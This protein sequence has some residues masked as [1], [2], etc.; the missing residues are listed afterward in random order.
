MNT[1]S[2]KIKREEDDDG[3]SAITIDR[4]SQL[5][6]PVLHNILSLL[7]Q[8]DAIRTSVLSNSWRYL[9][10]GRLN[11]EFRDNWFAR[12]PEL[13]SFLDKTLQRY[14]DHNFSLQKF[15]VDIRSVV[16]YTLL[17]KWISMA[18]TNM[19][20]KSLNLIF[21][22]SS[23]D[24]RRPLIAFLSETLVELHLQNCNLN[25][26]KSTD[27]VMLNNLRTLLLHSVYITDENFDKIISGCPLIEKLYLLLMDSINPGERMKAFID[28]PNILYFAYFGHG[29]LPSIKF[30]TTSNEWASHI[31][32]WPSDNDAMSW[33][34][35][36]N[37]LLKALSQSHIT[38]NLIH[39]EYKKLNII[40]SY[41]GFD[42]PVVVKHLGL[43]GYFSSSSFR[44]ILNCYF[45]VCRP[46]YIH[47]DQ[48]ANE[49][50]DIHMDQYAN[51][52]AEFICNLIPN[53]IGWCYSWLQ[54]LE[55][56]RIEVLDYK[57]K[58]WNCF[59]GTTLPS[60]Q[61]FRFRLTWREQLSKLT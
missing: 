61:R 7:S 42:K 5:P 13:W 21:S 48:Y 41:G 23:I 26:L 34:L 9:W 15:L 29:F 36:L 60:S 22:C 20:V 59:Q 1:Q 44:A 52:F 37:K 46:R 16:D 27:D 30:T 43:L 45:R 49:L 14:L 55:E 11:V 4:L 8:K 58:E 56:V 54:D 57:A 10:H 50:T 2:V 31:S 53:N 12:K 38:L 17:Q 18:I 28:T 32:V 40:D 35:E 51:K 6:Q 24:F 33:F 3:S 47:M 25:T 19:G 39:D